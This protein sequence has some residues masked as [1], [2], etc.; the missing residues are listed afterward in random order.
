MKNRI[1]VCWLLLHGLLAGQ[2]AVKKTVC[3]S[4]CDYTATRAGL[5]AALS[6][7]AISQASACAPYIIEIAAGTVIEISGNPGLSLP[8]KSCKQFVTIRSTGAFTEGAR[9]NPTTESGSLATLK[10][11]DYVGAILNLAGATSYWRLEGIDFW[12]E[13]GAYNNPNYYGF[14]LESDPPTGADP[15]TR[16]HHFEIRH[17]WFRGR[18]GARNALNGIGV[19]GSNIRI[20]DN[21]FEAW[22]GTTGEGRAIGIGAATGVEIRNNRLTGAAQNVLVGGL[23]MP[24]GVIPSLI[25]FIGNSF[26]RDPYMRYWTGSANPTVGCREGNVYRNT[27]TGSDWIC[28]SSGVWVDQAGTSAYGDNLVKT[29]LE[30]KE[31]RGIKVFGNLFEG[32]WYPLTW[33]MSNFISMHATSSNVVSLGGGKYSTNDAWA[34]ITDTK[35]WGNKFTKG[36]AILSVGYAAEVPCTK[37]NLTGC[38]HTGTNN[39]RMWDNL[40]YELSDEKD[41]AGSSFG[42]GGYAQWAVGTFDMEYR[43]NTFLL[44]R[45]AGSGAAYYIGNVWGGNNDGTLVN[46]QTIYGQNILRDNIAPT[47]A[48]GLKGVDGVNNLS[49][50]GECGL[51]LGVVPNVGGYDARN[52]I[53]TNDLPWYWPGRGDPYS[54]IKNPLSCTWTMWSPDGNR[55]A[56]DWGVWWTSGVLLQGSWNSVVSDSTYKVI[57]AYQG[58]GSDGRDPGANIDFVNWAT[59]GAAT[60]ALNPFL[61]MKIRSIRAS[62]NAATLYVTTPSSQACTVELSKSNRFDTLTG[63]AD[64]SQTGKDVRATVSGLTP[65]TYYFVR[66]RCDAYQL[67]SAL[68]TSP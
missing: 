20:L 13:G 55:P 19:N 29:I 63:S 48:G 50:M 11:V 5:T 53:W 2:S 22:A 51:A 9:L 18:P 66:V 49:T 46:L 59:A 15:A 56:S 54:G 36:N 1:L 30:S 3:A 39:I 42:G 45:T 32:A 25:S 62:S 26:G 33:T 28:N 38:L 24:A 4:G 31:S 47:T 68:L 41:L 7:A 8:V 65:G 16:P 17:C 14:I 61:D 57:G 40:G 34:T 10:A 58:T 64:Y 60:G 35:I 44:S 23:G 67:E 6:A 37:D 43:N 27:N 12:V 52:N 21:Y